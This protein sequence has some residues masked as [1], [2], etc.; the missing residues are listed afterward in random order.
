[1]VAEPGSGSASSLTQDAWLIK[2]DPT[3]NDVSSLQG[4]ISFGVHSASKD[5]PSAGFDYGLA[6]FMDPSDKSVYEVRF[7][8]LDQTSP[9]V[10]YDGVALLK[11]VF[12]STGFGPSN[13]PKTVAYIAAF[14]KSDIYKNGQKIAG[15]VPAHVIVTPGLRDTSG[16]LLAADNLDYSIRQISLHVPGP[17]TGLPDNK[18]FVSWQN[19]A[20][21]LR[22]VGGRPLTQRQVAMV[23]FPRTTG[24]VAG[25]AAEVP[26]GEIRLS[27]QNNGF[28]STIPDTLTSGFTTVTVVNNSSMSRGAIIKAKDVIGSPIVR[29]TPI[30]RPG[31]SYSFNAYL[32]S[33]SFTAMDYHHG[34]P[35]MRPWRSNYQTS[36][37]IGM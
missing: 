8:G 5:L 7:T 29:Y 17:I 25:A 11:P 36:F 14:G 30:L 35:G 4:L 1:M 3:S 26:L 9:D 6:K 21:D 16:K 22:D 31:Q 20:I 27:L 12:G 24:V 32:G 13:L 15:D 18:M 10:R 2:G 28:S 33:G 23:T 34:T 37:S 19:A